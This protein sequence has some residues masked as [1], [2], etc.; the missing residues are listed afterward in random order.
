MVNQLATELMLKWRE[1]L[2]SGMRKQGNGSLANSRGEFC[3]LGVVCDMMKL[4]YEDTG[5]TLIYSYG[6][7]EKFPLTS[8]LPS[9]IL[10]V[11][12]ITQDDQI[13][14]ISMNDRLGKTFLEIADWLEEKYP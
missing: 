13:F 4:D 12:G 9:G 2:R 1:E 7:L 5:K 10:V 14:L 8:S 6:P 3:C 11:L